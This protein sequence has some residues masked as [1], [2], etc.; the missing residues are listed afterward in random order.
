MCFL[1]LLQKY[2]VYSYLLCLSLKQW[3][4]RKPGDPEK[5]VSSQGIRASVTK[6]VFKRQFF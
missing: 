2:K 1:T 4:Q 6:Y 5:G 3:N